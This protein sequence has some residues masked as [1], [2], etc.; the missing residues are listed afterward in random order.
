MARPLI[1]WIGGRKVIGSWHGLLKLSTRSAKRTTP[2]NHRRES[3]SHNRAIRV[4]EACDFF[5]HKTIREI[6]RASYLVW[7]KPRS[8]L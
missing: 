5:Y 8:L 6:S 1:G 7:G 2:R 3:T 4:F